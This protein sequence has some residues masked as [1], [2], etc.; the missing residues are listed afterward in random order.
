MSVFVLIFSVVLAFMLDC[1]RVDL[2]DPVLARILDTALYNA[3]A[4]E[5]AILCGLFGL[6]FVAQA[7]L[8]RA[9]LGADCVTGNEVPGY[10]LLI[11]FA[12]A[13]TIVTLLVGLNWIFVNFT[14]DSR[15]NSPYECGFEPVNSPVTDF[16][17]NFLSVALVFLIYDVEVLLTFP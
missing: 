3:R 13:L 8:P 10:A 9:P 17:P 7:P 2:L 6:F 15:K 11:F 1:Y 14:A 5:G 4:D 16:S 12:V